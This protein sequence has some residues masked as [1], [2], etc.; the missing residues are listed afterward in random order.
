MLKVKLPK[1]EMQGLYR[2]EVADKETG[3]IK[4]EIPWVENLITNRGLDELGL[5]SGVARM[6][7]YCIVGS[8]STTPAFTDEVTTEVGYTSG[9]Q[10]AIDHVS[11]TNERY[12][13]SNVYKY[14]INPSTNINIS[15]L[16]LSSGAKNLSN[17]FYLSTRALIKDQFGVPTTL[18]L[19]S[20]EVLNIYYEIRIYAPKL[21]EAI[22]TQVVG[23]DNDG[24]IENYNL[25]IQPYNLYSS[26]WVNNF[27]NI[28]YNPRVFI[29]SASSTNNTTFTTSPSGTV[30]TGVTSTNIHP[31]VQGTY[32]RGLDYSMDTSTTSG[33]EW[34]NV[35]SLGIT[36][37]GSL[38]YWEIKIE[39]ESDGSPL[40]KTQYQQF[41][42]T[43]LA[44]WGRLV[45]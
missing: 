21:S 39:K 19:L 44:S 24:T 23:L 2:Y 32:Q 33:V 6:N 17:Q 14:V 40:T 16:G 26:T 43:F 1:V 45:P 38:G 20:T 31:Y 8:N 5:L 9:T 11:D 18:S 7:A 41:D 25:T 35:N 42:I 12:Y 10:F 15:D 36:T 29:Y 37:S 34:T 28:F 27:S 30:S 4:K 13:K 22:T 3:E